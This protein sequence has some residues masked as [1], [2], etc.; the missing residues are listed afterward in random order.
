MKRAMKSKKAFTLVELIVVMALMGILGLGV[1]MIF[2]SAN[3]TTV[4]LA[5]Q[6]DINMKTNYAMETI[7]TQL[8]FAEGLTVGSPAEA[9]TDADKRY[10]YSEDGRV[11][12][13]EGT[14]PE[15]NLF[16]EAF[17]E[18]YLIDME[19]TPIQK[20]VVRLSITTQSRNNAAVSYNLETEVSALNTPTVE[21]AGPGSLASYKWA[22]P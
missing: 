9:G 10:L 20:S 13:Q 5:E 22:R 11:Y 7:Q 14:S 2:L 8:R 18:G 12:I 3:N 1:T 15:R 21:G 4:A 16:G 6:T 17:Y 19:M